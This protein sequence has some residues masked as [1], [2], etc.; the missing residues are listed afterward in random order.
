MT[1]SVT[2]IIIDDHAVVREGLRVRLEQ[3]G[4]VRV[5]GEA[6]SGEEAIDQLRSHQPDVALLDVAIP[7]FDGLEVARRAAEE[8][9]STR[10][11][12][13]SATIDHTLIQRAFAV[14]ALGFIGK[15]AKLDIVASAIRTVMSG[16]RFVDPAVAAELLDEAG[17]ALTEREQK[18]LQLMADGLT[19]IGI[20]KELSLAEDTVKAHVSSVLRKLDASSRTAA[21]AT[22]FRQN[23]VH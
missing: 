12:I 15:D 4:V 8:S 3:E 13:F 23:I 19:N 16:K 17:Q 2:C 18:T 14:G 7:G 22:A 10:L 5:V 9:I 21:V 11:I 20:A 1:E 6:G